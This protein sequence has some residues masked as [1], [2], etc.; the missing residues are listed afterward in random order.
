MMTS[1]SAF[2]GVHLSYGRQPFIV[3]VLDDD[4][5]LILHANCDMDELRATL[6]DPDSATVCVVASSSS[7]NA[8]FANMLSMFYE[9]LEKMSFQPYATKNATRQWSRVNADETFATFLQK[10]L[11]S[12]RTLEG[13]I[14]RALILYDQGLQIKDPMEFFEEITRYKLIQGI[15]PLETLY[16]AKELDA[17]MAG[18]VAWLTVHRPGQMEILPG[19]MLLPTELIED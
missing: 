3:A 13:R 14:Q 11:L 2:V 15:L 19:N 8:K 17:L 1:T 9:Q 5:N 16:T 18:Y 7:R 4:L 12:R 10:K 6:S